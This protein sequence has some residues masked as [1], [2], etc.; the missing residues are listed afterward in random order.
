MRKH[1]PVPGEQE[2]GLLWRR[3]P[4]YKGECAWQRGPRESHGQLIRA[5]LISP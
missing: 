5:L 3:N 2:R 1:F 4:G